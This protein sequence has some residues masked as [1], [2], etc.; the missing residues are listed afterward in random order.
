MEASLRKNS[1]FTHVY[2]ELFRAQ[3]REGIEP[4]TRGFSVQAPNQLK[5]LIIKGLSSWNRGIFHL[6]SRG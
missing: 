5:L 4:P 2:R 1:H 6:V 3:S